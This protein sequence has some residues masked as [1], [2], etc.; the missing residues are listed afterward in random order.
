MSKYQVIICTI[1]IIEVFY[2]L[3]FMAAKVMLTSLVSFAARK[4]LKL[5]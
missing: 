3:A 1:S 2:L 5:S 4:H